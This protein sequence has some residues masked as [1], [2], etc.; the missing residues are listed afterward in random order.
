MI[1]QEVD[2]TVENALV[3]TRRGK[4]GRLGD[5]VKGMK[6]TLIVMGTEKCI[7]LLSHK[8]HLELV[9]CSE[10]I[11]LQCKINEGTVRKYFLQ[12]AR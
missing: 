10:F 11:P 6:N 1:N 8:E 4:G 3:V 2:S 7:V 9:R 12:N 5:Q